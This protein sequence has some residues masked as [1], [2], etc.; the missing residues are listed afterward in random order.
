MKKIHSK[1]PVR[2][3][4]I[5]H[6]LIIAIIFSIPLFLQGQRSMERQDRGV[7]AVP[8]QHGGIFI[9]WRLLN[10]DP[11]GGYYNVFRKNADGSVVKVNSEPIVNKTN[12]EDLAVD[13]AKKNRYY[14]EAVNSQV[15]ST[16]ET[17]KV[18][19]S[20]DGFALAAVPS[21]PYFSIPLRN[22]PEIHFC[23]VGDLDGD[24]T[25][26]YVIDRLNWGV[27]TK[28]EAYR[29]NGTFLWD[30]DYGPNSANTDN[31]SPGS[32]T[33]DVG[34]WD[35]VTVADLNGDGR[36]EVITKI[37]NGVRL[38][39]GEVWNN[40]NNNLQWMAVL[41][42]RNGARLGTIQLPTDY[43]STG[44]L[45]CQVGVGN[46]N[47]IFVHAKNRNSNG[48][49]N[50]VNVVYSV[51]GS[52]ALT[53]KWKRIG[54]GAEGHQIRIVD[55]NEDGID[56]MAHIGYVLNGVN[57]TVLYTIPGV[58]HGDRFH[59]GKFDPNRPG[60]QGYGV[61]QVNPSG[62]LEY[63]YDARNGQILWTH[64]GSPADVGRGNAADIDPSRPG[65][66]V[67][68]FSG[69]YNAPTNAKLT[70]EPN[71]PWP[72]FRL[73]WDAD[74]GSELFDNGKIE[75]WNPSTNSVQRLLTCS[76][77]E[78]A[79]GS[80]RGAPLFYGDIWG[81]WR[82]EVIMRNST[83]NR[84]IIFTTNI[85][86]TINRGP[87]TQDRYYRNCLTLKGYMQSHHT[88][89]YLGEGGGSN[90]V[91]Y[92]QIQNRGTG[93]FLDGMGRTT[94][95]EA[96]VQYANTSHV[97]AQWERI[98]AGS[99][100]QLRNRGTGMMLDGMGRTTDGAD[101]GQY[102]SS[103]S[104][105]Q[106]WSV[107][108][109]SGNYYRIQNRGTG[110]YLDGMGRTSNGSACGQYANATSVNAQ[111]QMLPV[112]GA[113]VALEEKSVPKVAV[114]EKPSWVRVYPNPAVNEIRIVLPATYKAGRW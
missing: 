21:E 65:Y 99:Y 91:T 76:Q 81:D 108:P 50:V 69:I 29:S 106:Q 2:M 101:A 36:A 104:N 100:Y 109:Y 35:G 42:G 39:N 28:L 24:G 90:P 61:Q 82:E 44:P 110:L 113:R 112:S 26:D 96:C 10:T 58:I 34:H 54:G 107:Q 88:S 12:L 27:G 3:R 15:K 41:D 32:A 6:A 114:E 25:N 48:S 5:L 70:D 80:A 17:I 67:W 94:N 18:P 33:I 38:G 89:Y 8:G 56:D 60:L 62:M 20:D 71:R 83:N 14:V 73:W 30:I 95:G 23:W 9:S 43:L 53:Q 16:G 52:G 103:G 45:A 87:L 79:T 111:W 37:A 74:N 64:T 68:S 7:V 4:E 13:P 22:G 49:F 59:I 66:E 93:L 46:N 102:A 63:Y 1:Q 84:L 78:G 19:D 86:T 31:I 57:G 85:P 105:N 75:A 40:S 51:S 97:N 55:V 11:Q 77:Y 47:E 98:S 92:Y 72:N